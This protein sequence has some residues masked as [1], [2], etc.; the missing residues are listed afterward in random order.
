MLEDVPPKKVLLRG[1]I[2]QIRPSKHWIESKFDVREE[3]AANRGN[4]V[5]VSVLDAILGNG[6]QIVVAGDRGN[7]VRLRGSLDERCKDVQ[8]LQLAVGHVVCGGG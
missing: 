6:E 3:Q 2:N 8:E 4:V 7:M 5:R 1:S